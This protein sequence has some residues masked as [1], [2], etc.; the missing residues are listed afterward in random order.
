M[1][2]D[3]GDVIEDA[4]EKLNFHSAADRLTAVAAEIEDWRLQ[5]L[6]D[7]VYWVESSTNRFGRENVS[8][9]A[10]PIDIGPELRTHLFNKVKTCVLTSATIAVGSDSL[11][12]FNSRLV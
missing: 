1:V 12:I 5:R 6:D 3:R 8:L 10:A 4:S 7:G 9:K 11:S 2:K